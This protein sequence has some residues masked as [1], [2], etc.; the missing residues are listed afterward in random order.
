M[1]PLSVIYFHNGN[2]DIDW[3]K[4]SGNEKS[5]PEFKL[6]VFS[7]LKHCNIKLRLKKDCI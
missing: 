2:N 3:L 5:R 4:E 6:N 7:Y 1:S